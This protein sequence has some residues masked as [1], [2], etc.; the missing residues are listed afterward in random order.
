MGRLS[1]PHP[2]AV[3]HNK[4]DEERKLLV[5]AGLALVMM[6][7]VVVAVVLVVVGVVSLGS[8]AVIVVDD[9]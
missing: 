1:S 6:T 8:V 5:S 7:V 3:P 4:A 9:D 2:N